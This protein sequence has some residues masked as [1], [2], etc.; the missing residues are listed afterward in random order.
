MLFRIRKFEREH[1]DSDK[2]TNM[3]AR[4]Q[5]CFNT[6]NLVMKSQ[7]PHMMRLKDQG[8]RS[9]LF[10]ACGGNDTYE[11]VRFE[12]EFYSSKYIDTKECVLD[13]SKYLLKLD[14]ERRIK[15]NTPL[16]VPLPIL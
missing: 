1:W 11:H 12:C 5:A 3:M 15:F 2:F 6:G 7:S 9:C 14:E 10:P 13:N 8:D 4:A 16:I